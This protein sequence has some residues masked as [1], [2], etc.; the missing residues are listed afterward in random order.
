MKSLEHYLYLFKRH[1]EGLKYS[2]STISLKEY[3]LIFFVEYLRSIGRGHIV[4]VKDED[5]RGYAGSLLSKIS[6]RKKN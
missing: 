1:L 2:K 4:D 3:S 5:V 6:N